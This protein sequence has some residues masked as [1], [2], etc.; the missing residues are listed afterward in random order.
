MVY[1]KKKKIM[2]KETSKHVC[3]SK[4]CLAEFCFQQRKDSSTHLI[5]SEMDKCLKQ[6]FRLPWESSG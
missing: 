6:W 3:L 2:S 4:T 5:Q 1:K